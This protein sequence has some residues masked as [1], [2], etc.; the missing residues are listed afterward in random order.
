MTTAADERPPETISPDL[1]LHSSRVDKTLELD[2][3]TPQTEFLTLH[4]RAAVRATELKIVC[5]VRDHS[6][7]RATTDNCFSDLRIHSSRVDKTL[8]LD[9]DAPDRISDSTPPRGG[10]CD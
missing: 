5:L 7:R 1:R 2:T 6:R 10:A 4:P 8:E 3:A 9:R